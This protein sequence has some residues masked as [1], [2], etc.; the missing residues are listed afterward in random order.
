M[1][2]L[3]TVFTSF[4]LVFLSHA[5]YSAYEHSLL[6]SSASSPASSASSSAIDLPIDVILELLISTLVTCAGI[7]LGSPQLRPIQWSVWAG[8]VEREGRK[9]GAWEEG[10][11]NPFRSLDERL[12]FLDIRAQRKQFADWVRNGQGAQSKG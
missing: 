12:G 7:V 4:G 3:S 9:P 1:G 11:G 2:F 6:L 10:V 5:V 8:K